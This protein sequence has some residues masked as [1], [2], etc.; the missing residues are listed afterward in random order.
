MAAGKPHS[1]LHVDKPEIDLDPAIDPRDPLV[2]QTGAENLRR[3]LSEDI[4]RQDSAQ[5]FYVYQQIL[6]SH[7]QTGLGAVVAVDEYEQGVIRK[8]EFTRPDKEDDRVRHMEAL[9]M[10][11][12]P[13][14]LTYRADA[15]IDAL[16][17]DV[18]SAEP[19][20]DFID[21]SQVRHQ[22]WPVFDVNQ[23]DKLGAA[24]QGV[25][26]LYVAD[27]HHRSAAAARVCRQ[28]RA[29]N[30]AHQGSE[31]Y[32]FFLAVVFPHDQM[33]IL[34]YNRVVKDLAGLSA[35]EFLARLAQD[36]LLETMPDAE[37]A[38]PARRHDFGMYL[39]GTWYRLRLRPG[40]T[41]SLDAV[42]RLD[43]SI[44]QDR[45]LAPIL[46]IGDPRTDARIDF[47]GGIRGM[48]A[49][50]RAVDSGDQ[51]VAFACHPTSIDELLAIADAG[52]VMP[53]KSTWFE[54][55][56]KSGL[57]IHSLQ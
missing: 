34:D 3:L 8:H 9:N 1:F 13:V 50:R 32:N 23:I 55:K 36:F 43:V 45:V 29:A 31:A 39:E 22:L 24:F 48:E 30:P 7:R 41:E 42:A 46:N 2:Y 21:D 20:Y 52:K 53:P 11:V 14:F 5:A 28:R 54:P 6:G 16:I 19:A 25:P 40:I 15:A 27:G 56:L 17:E 51:A 35:S 4:L 44:L 12:G 10:Q 49:L 33:R 57:L 18:T 47:I 37:S 26:R 38:K